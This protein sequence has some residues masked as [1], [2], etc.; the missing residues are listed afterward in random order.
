[1]NQSKL[2]KRYFGKDSHGIVLFHI[3][4]IYVLDPRAIEVKISVEYDFS[5]TFIPV[6]T[7]QIKEE[8]LSEERR[9]GLIALLLLAIKSIPGIRFEILNDDTDFSN[10]N[11]EYNGYRNVLDSIIEKAD[12]NDFTPFSTNRNE[13]FF[14]KIKNYFSENKTVFKV[15]KKEDF[16]THISKNVELANEYI[17][18]YDQ[19]AKY[20]SVREINNATILHFFILIV[21]DQIQL[22]FFKEE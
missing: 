8:H 15:Y 18:Y 3:D 2:T 20:F 19:K 12:F 17:K 5:K 13:L 11:G 14:Q 1:M 4:I 6:L 21:L 22:V 9:L 7:S 10:W 16:E